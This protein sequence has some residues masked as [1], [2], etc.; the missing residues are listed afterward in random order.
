M[1][2]RRALLLQSNARVRALLRQ[3]LELQDFRATNAANGN[4]AWAHLRA[5][6]FDLIV[7]DTVLSGMDMTTLCRAIRKAGPNQQSSIIIVSASGEEAERVLALASGADDYLTIPFS[8]HELRARIRALMR[9]SALR[10]AL[11]PRRMRDAGDLT[12]DPDRRTAMVD[13]TLLPL[14]RR[15]FDLLYVLMASPGV[16]FTRKD[17]LARLGGPCSAQSVRLKPDTTAAAAAT[18]TT[19]ATVEQPDRLVDPIVSRLRA[20][21]KRACLPSRLIRT[22]P[23]MG[24]TFVG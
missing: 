22:V 3:Q 5:R 4:A 10:H 11:G 2:Q 24:Y 18:V 19:T 14:T 20:K 12:L 17:L 6:A 7:L 13:R 23:G 21:L 15:E 16:V 9:R 8:V 1:T